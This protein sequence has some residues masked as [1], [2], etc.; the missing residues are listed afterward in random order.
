[1]NASTILTRRF[2]R[3]NMLG[4][5]CWHQHCCDIVLFL[6]I[7]PTYKFI[8]PSYI[9]CGYTDDRIV[10][11]CDTRI[12]F[13]HIVVDEFVFVKNTPVG[14]KGGAGRNPVLKSLPLDDVCRLLVVA[15]IMET[16]TSF[17]NGYRDLTSL[18]VKRAKYN[19]VHSFVLPTA[20]TRR[21]SPLPLSLSTHTHTHTRT[22]TRPLSCTSWAGCLGR[23][24]LW[25]I[26]KFRRR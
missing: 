18:V 12:I 4:I 16:I 20:S 25:F 5:A 6:A 15:G 7:P 17:A 1:M 8:D 2:P 22:R 10:P 11:A 24:R 3:E 21:I 9:L 14:A 19:I 23:R 26:P 13:W